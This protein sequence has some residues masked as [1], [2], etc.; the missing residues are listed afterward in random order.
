MSTI[1]HLSA[2]EAHPDRDAEARR[3]MDRLNRA[4]VAEMNAALAF[5]NVI[6]PEAFEIA[7]QAVSPNRDDLPDD[8]DPVPVCGRCGGPVALFPDQ[9]MTWSH[10]QA[11]ASTAGHQEITDPGHGPQVEWYLPDEVPDLF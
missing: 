6:D 3:R 5:L 10:Y 2:R 8:E 7:F 11:Q 1:I 4:T 9:G